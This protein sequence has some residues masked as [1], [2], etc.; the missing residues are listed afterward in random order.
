MQA[1]AKAQANKYKMH[2]SS[3]QV[4]KEATRVYQ[5]VIRVLFSDGEDLSIKKFSKQ[6]TISGKSP[7]NG[8]QLYDQYHDYLP[9]NVDRN[10]R[11]DHVLWC[12]HW[13]K[14]DINY[15]DEYVVKSLNHKVSYCEITRL[16]FNDGWHY[17]VNIYLQGDA[18]LKYTT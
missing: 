8:I 11:I 9:K 1:Y 17:Y 2:V 16:A 15:A 14:L 6:R 12:G 10:G 3:Q 13:F 7:T 5:G 18:P 4:Q